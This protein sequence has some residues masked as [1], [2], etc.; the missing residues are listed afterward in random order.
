VSIYWLLIAMPAAA[1][2]ENPG[3]RRPLIFFVA[4]V[5]IVPLAALIVHSTEHSGRAHGRGA[6]RLASTRR[7]ATCRS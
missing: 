5:A 6:R 3:G 4:A 2:L 1:G 7:S